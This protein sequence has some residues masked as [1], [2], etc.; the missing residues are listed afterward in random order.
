M[1]FG[2]AIACHVEASPLIL[3]CT[4]VA[5]DAFQGG[6]LWAVYDS[7]PTLENCIVAF[8]LDGSGVFSFPN[9]D[10]PAEINLVCCDV[11]GNGEGNYGGEMEDQTGI[12]G[13]ISIHPFFCDYEAGDYTLAAGSPCLP[14]NNECGVL[15]GAYGQ[16]C[17]HPTAATEPAPDA[18][19]LAQNAPNPF[20]PRTEIRFALPEAGRVDLAVFDLAGRRV[21]RLIEGQRLEQ[22]EHSAIWQGR[23]DAGRAL[24]SGVYLYRLEAGPLS[25]TKKMTLLQ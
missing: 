11:F 13:N 3:G 14:E 5:N 9:A 19:R 18:L 4:L 24:A 10:H 2:G 23:D 7:Y 25:A 1:F 22:G 20:N 12:D 16:G 15:M 21:R 6:G 17:D 8:N